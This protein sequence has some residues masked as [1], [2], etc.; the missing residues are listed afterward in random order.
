VVGVPAVPVVDGT[1]TVTVFGGC[2][3]VVVG[4]L[5]LM[6]VVELVVVGSL[7]V[8]VCGFVECEPELPPSETANAIATPTAA[9]A[10]TARTVIHTRVRS[11]CCG[12]PQ[13]G[14]ALACAESGAPQLAQ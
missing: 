1:V 10:T 4:V 3:T 11:L 8:F 6:F 12:V 5:T 9:T 2:V 13:F 14:H 7:A